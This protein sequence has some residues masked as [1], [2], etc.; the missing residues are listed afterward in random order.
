MRDPGAER[1]AALDAV[2]VRGDLHDVASLK[3]ALDG[4]RGVFSVQSPDLLGNSEV[5]HGRNLVE[6]AR[7]CFGRASA[8]PRRSWTPASRPPSRNRVV[9]RG[10]WRRCFRRGGT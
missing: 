2:L 4:A 5:R 8:R 7:V 6:A 9:R 10:P 3:A 1:A